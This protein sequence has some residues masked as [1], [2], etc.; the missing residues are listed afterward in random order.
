M[1]LAPM[2]IGCAIWLLRWL[3]ANRSPEN[4][5]S[6]NRFAKAS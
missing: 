1:R 2:D 5:I 4:E 6:P 3:K